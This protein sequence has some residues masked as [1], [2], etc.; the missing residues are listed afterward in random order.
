[1]IELESL[2]IHRILVYHLVGLILRLPFDYLKIYYKH[3]NR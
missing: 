1:M 3:F 2:L